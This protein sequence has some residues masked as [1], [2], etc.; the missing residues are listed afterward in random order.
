MLKLNKEQSENINDIINNMADALVSNPT[1]KDFKELIEILQEYGYEEKEDKKVLKDLIIVEI[2]DLEFR[3]KNGNIING[4][5]RLSNIVLENQNNRYETLQ[6]KY[7]NLNFPSELDNELKRASRM[8]DSYE[9]KGRALV[10]DCITNKLHESEFI[11]H[12]ASVRVLDDSKLNI[13]IELYK[14]ND[15][16]AYILNVDNR[17]VAGEYIEEYKVKL[18]MPC[19]KESYLLEFNQIVEKILDKSTYCYSV[20]EAELVKDLMKLSKKYKKENKKMSNNIVE[21]I[22]NLKNKRFF[23]KN[24]NGETLVILHPIDTKLSLRYNDVSTLEFK[25]YK[26]E[27]PCYDL[28]KS[29]EKVKIE[30]VEFIFVIDKTQIVNDESNEYKIIHCKF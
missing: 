22:K 29:S 12:N 30:D 8:S 7:D 5:D 9:V 4:I 16:P 19:C 3:D 15:E 27:C 13:T 14:S 20:E 25:I 11:A 23:L 21:E 18:D 26:D 1:V 17:E 28:L 10:K 24:T 6:G 2:K